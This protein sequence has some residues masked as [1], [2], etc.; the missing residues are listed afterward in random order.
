MVPVGAARMFRSAANVDDLKPLTSLR[1]VAA[2]MIVLLHSLVYFKSQWLWLTY[3]PQTAV[4]GVS[5]FFVLSGFILTHVY[6]RRQYSYADFLWA[7]F[8]RLWPMHIATIAL[9]MFC[10]R[11][12]SI[13]FDGPGLFSKW[14]TLAANVTLTHAVVPYTA[15]TFS[16]NSVSWSI[17]TE[18]FFYL[19]FPLLLI[20][21]R[22]TWR[23]KL[24]SALAVVCLM[25]LAGKALAL[26]AQ[27]GVYDLTL[28]SLL[29]T[30]PATRGFE[31]CL[32]MAAYV[33][34]MR[35]RRIEMGIWLATATEAA[36]V[37]AAAVWLRYGF[38]WIFAYL[39]P[40]DGVS[41]IY[42][43][44]GSSFVFAAVFVALADAK[45]YIGQAL[46]LPIAVWLG[47]ISFAV[48]MVHQ[49]VMKIIALSHPQMTS[50]YIVYGSIIVLAALLHH[51][52][53]LPARK[54]IL[55]RRPARLP[56]LSPAA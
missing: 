35:F 46:S 27:G 25:L 32:G 31:F 12:D 55:K 13:T 7:R 56:A 53:E 39:A 45:G 52:I 37:A 36:V 24:M 22:E 8:A 49:L 40:Y 51:L 33:F 47:E 6:S 9:V 48:Y 28:E 18:M 5:F 2:M 50:P 10:V 41:A 42:G 14:V 19:A 26:P 16:W 29:A 34:W 11:A 38:N 3:V 23:L 1:F 4:Q 43:L 21:I 20:N 54:L 17:S 30:N 44:S 15:F